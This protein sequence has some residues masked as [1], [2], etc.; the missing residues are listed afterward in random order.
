M[1]TKSLQIFPVSGSAEV[2]TSLAQDGLGHVTAGWKGP[3]SPQS[4]PNLLKATRPWRCPDG[5]MPLVSRMSPNSADRSGSSWAVCLSVSLTAGN[6]TSLESHAS[7]PNGGN[8][9]SVRRKQMP[10]PQATVWPQAQQ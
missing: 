10:M 9:S 5:F 7:I 1:S 4:A 8:G 2:S 6:G 3:R